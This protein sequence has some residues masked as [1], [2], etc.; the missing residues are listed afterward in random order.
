MAHLQIALERAGFYARD[1]LVYRRSS[2]IP[3]GLNIA[4][5]MKKKGSPDWKNWEG[6]H[7]C[8]RSEWEAIVV[9]QK[10]LVTNYLETLSQYGVGLFRATNEDGSFQSNIL[11]DIPRE[12]NGDYN[13]HCTVKPLALMEKLINLFVP[14]SNEHIV[15]DPFAGSGTTL[16]AAK[17]LGRSFIGIEIVPEYIDII[18]TRLTETEAGVK[19]A[20]PAIEKPYTLTL[21][22]AGNL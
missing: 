2:G 22:P 10:P 15:L 1:C 12:K 8:L 20:P 7:S 6:W 17:K 5:Q 21:W 9:V 4:S 11:E 18:K 16:V 14:P 3:K 19:S 13:V